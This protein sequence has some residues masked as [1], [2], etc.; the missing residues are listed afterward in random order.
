MSK[1]FFKKI[2]FFSIFLYFFSC[3]FLAGCSDRTIPVSPDESNGSEHRYAYGITINALHKDSIF[4]AL[5]AYSARDFVLP[6]HFFDNPVHQHLDTVVH[7]LSV[8]DFENKPVNYSSS[9]AS[10][11]AIQ[12]TILHLEGSFAYPVT[13]SYTIDPDAIG[14]DEPLGIDAATLTD[15][16]LLFLGSA[17]LIV[18]YIASS[19]EQFWR[20]NMQISV[21]VN[22]KSSIS[23]FGIPSSGNYTCKNIYELLFT[24]LYGCK[25]SLYSGY[26]GGVQ[27]TFLEFEN[28]LIPQDSLPVIGSNFTKILNVLYLQYGKFN[29]N[30]FTVHFS[31]IGGGL[32]GLFSFTQMDC[33]SPYFYYVLAHETLHQFIGI[34]CGDYDDPWWKEGAT[35]YLS[36]LVAVRL[37]LYPKNDFR[38]YITRKFAFPDSSSFNIALSDPWVRLNMFPSGKWDI[39]Y[40]KGAQVMMLLDYRT[41]VA[42]DNRYSIDDVMSYLVNQFDG[43]AFHRKDLLDAFVKF[44]NPDVGDIFNTYIDVA[45]EHPSDSLLSFTYGKLDSLGAFGGKGSK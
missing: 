29:D 6:Y 12:N 10:V 28:N 36:Y 44:G 37:E 20:T 30:Q 41:R 22:N 38:N 34:R 33:S 23:L 11:G 13:L 4:F 43:S 17:V 18:P 15:S 42:S 19:M 26:G 2:T 8:M 25:S 7:H 40:T 1:T 9:V 5:T 27:F 31:G 21:S 24:Q 3:F 16:T 39:V 45:G 32:E 14:N 35:S